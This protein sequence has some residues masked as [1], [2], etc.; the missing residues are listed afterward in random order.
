MSK[1]TSPA[2]EKPILTIAVPTYN[3]SRYIKRLVKS[4]LIQDLKDTEVIFV[5]D[6]SSDN[7]LDIIE[8]IFE[9]ELLHEYKIY[10][11]IKNVGLDLNVINCLKKSK[12]NFVWLLGHDDF[13]VL[14]AVS[15]VIS[16]LKEANGVGGLFLNYSIFDN[17]NEQIAKKSWVTESDENLIL[18]GDEFWTLLGAAPSFISSMIHNK[19]IALSTN[20][21]RYIGTNWLD[22]AI[23]LEYAKNN[24]MSSVAGL[25]LIAA[26]DSS[27]TPWNVE[28]AAL[29]AC[30]DLVEIILTH[31]ADYSPSAITSLKRSIFL[32]LNRKGISSRAAGLKLSKKLF[33]RLKRNFGEQSGFYLFIF[34]IIIPGALYRF[35]LKFYH[36]RHLKKLYWLLKKT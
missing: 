26:G 33:V 29:V 2:S 8:S 28:G 22:F 6:G 30:C 5:D 35:L 9:D 7:T 10:K 20:F 12:G 18:D 23:I 1:V 25:H 14:G 36:Q 4:I 24:K 3:S 11:N 21:E 31:S 19:E 16:A 27:E 34:S 15:A 17:R 13:L 32:V